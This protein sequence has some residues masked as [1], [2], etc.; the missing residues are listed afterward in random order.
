MNLLYQLGVSAVVL[1]LLAPLFGDVIRQPDASIYAVFAFQVLVVVA[2]G[3][4]VW[5]WVLSIY[6]VSNMASFSLLA[7]VAGVFFGA[8]IFDEEITGLFLVA[9]AMVGSGILLVNKQSPAKQIAA[10]AD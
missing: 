4:S 5:F 3:F 8:V 1:T 2:L 6:P 7:P 9:L 10:P